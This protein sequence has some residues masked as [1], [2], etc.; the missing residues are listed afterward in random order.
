MLKEKSRRNSDQQ[1]KTTRDREPKAEPLLMNE[2]EAAE[3][4]GFA[5][6]TLQTWRSRG[7]GPPFI[8]VS[9][10]CVRYQ[11][12]DLLAWIAERRRLS[13]SDRGPGERAD[14]EDTGGG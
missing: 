4:L 10:R 8:G 2:K 9:S 11:R 14:R 1:L 7:G 12:E 3:L 6:R 5:V 13:T